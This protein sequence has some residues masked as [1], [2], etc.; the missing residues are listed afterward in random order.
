[1]F[2]LVHVIQ[3]ASGDLVVQVISSNASL[4]EELH[5]LHLLSADH[6]GVLQVE[7]DDD[8]QLVFSTRLKESMFNIGEDYV[9]IVALGRGEAHTVLMD[10]DVAYR[11]FAYDVRPDHEILQCFLFAFDKH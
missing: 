7:V 1:M 8:N 3:S 2:K 11:L 6:D 9:Y 10:L 4:L 5:I